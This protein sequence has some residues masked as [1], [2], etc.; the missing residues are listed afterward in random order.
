MSFAATSFRPLTR[1]GWGGRA[2]SHF[3]G[4]LAVTMPDAGLPIED[5]QTLAVNRW[6]QIG[7]IIYRNPGVQKNYAISGITRDSAAVPIGSCRVELYQT[8]GDIPTLTTISDAS[9]N[10]RFD[11]PGSGPFYLVAYKAGAP[12]VAGTSI[13]TLLAT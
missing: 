12:D 11:S 7:T 10:F 4:A 6:G 2:A 8:G 3:R 13:N 5:P 9:G 1:S